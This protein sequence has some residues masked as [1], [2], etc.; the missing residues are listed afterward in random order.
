MKFTLYRANFEI[1]TVALAEF[2]TKDMDYLKFDQFSGS[3]FE[4]SNVIHSFTFNITSGGGSYTNGTYSLSL[5]GGGATTNAQVS[6]V[7]SG[8][9]I[10]SITVTDPGT[11]YTSNP[12]IS[13]SSIP[14][15][16]SHGSATVVLNAGYIQSYDTLYNVAK[17]YVEKGH[18]VANSVVGNG[19]SYAEIME[20]EDK[21]INSLTANIGYITHTPCQLIWSYSA[22]TNAGDETSAND[23]FVNFIPDKPEEL[24]FDASIR[25]YS[26]EEEN[27][28][29][30]KSFKIRAGMATQTSTVSPV[31]DLRKCS[32]IVTAND[33]NNSAEDED[34]SVGEALSKYVSRRVVLEDGQEAEDLRVYLSNSLPAGTDV[35]VYA[36]MQHEADPES[37][38]DKPWVLMDTVTPAALAPTGY[39]E[40][41][42]NLPAD[43]LNGDGI[44]EYVDNDVTYVG[45]KIFAI[46]V[47][48]LST[49]KCVVP[50]VRELRAIALQV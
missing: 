46:K 28:N 43:V 15:T 4:V 12:T 41:T 10:T 8:G 33:V 14:T 22:T 38:D 7:V 47:V 3:P 6:V 20:I 13:F 11:G 25:S 50:K 44:Y 49:K 36:K 32:M 31:I 9:N 17:V 40:Y 5:S 34:T 39:A 18:F 29:G 48:M 30:E 42:Y 21:L 37:F 35:Q 19:T 23:E 1:G 2:E 16:G 26:N 45:Y 27:L 24:R